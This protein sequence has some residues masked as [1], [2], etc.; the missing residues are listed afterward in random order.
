MLT[1]LGNEEISRMGFVEY[2]YQDP[3]EI[4]DRI[5][6]EYLEI[7]PENLLDAQRSSGKEKH[8]SLIGWGSGEHEHLSEDTEDWSDSLDDSDSSYW[9]NYL[10]GPDY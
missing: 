3:E 7:D 5:E 10:G 4:L 6:R 1:E 8:E 9:E 2:V